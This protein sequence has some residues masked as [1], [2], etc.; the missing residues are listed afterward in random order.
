MAV[1]TPT[2]EFTVLGCSGGP[3]AGKTCAFLLKPSSISFQQALENE[4]DCILALD[5]GAGIE[6]IAEMIADCRKNTASVSSYFNQLYSNTEDPSYYSDNSGLMD[7]EPFEDVSKNSTNSSLQL[8]KGILNRMAAYIITH[9]HLDHVLGLVINSPCF[10]QQTQIYGTQQTIDNLKNHIFNDKVWP[11]LSYLSFNYLQPYTENLNITESIAVETFQVS[12]GITPP[13]EVYKSSAFLFTETND[14]GKLLFF[15]DVESDLSSN[16]RYNQQ[17]WLKVA[18][19]ILG[20]ELKAIV[21]E[22]SSVD[23]KPGQ[24]LFGHMTPTNLISELLNLRKICLEK[25]K[26]TTHP[27]GGLNVLIIH[28]KETFD[29]LGDPRKQ[30]LES[31]RGLNQIHDLRIKFTICMPGISYF[32]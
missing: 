20:K 11:S 4:V 31:L 28:V 30:V 7:T 15:G 27:L 9:P 12:H 24:P 5:A 16:T 8:A 22:C 14:K 6:T 2:F 25:E 32:I 17:I 23:K 29:N 3:V 18:D 19:Y 1:N 21:I 10:T 13:T 26:A